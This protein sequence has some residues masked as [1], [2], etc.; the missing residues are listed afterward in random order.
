[1]RIGVG[2]GEAACSPTSQSIIADYFPAGK[3]ASAISILYLGI[4][5]GVVCSA[6]GTGYIVEHY[7]WREAFLVVGAPGLL[8]AVLVGL[9]LKEPPRGRFDPPADGSEPAP[10][11]RQVLSH[12]IHE[13]GLM[14][15]AFGIMF[16][17]MSA[18]SFGQFFHPLLVRFSGMGYAEAA[19]VFGIISVLTMGIGSPL[20]GYVTERF[21][22]RDARLICW[23]P[24]I[25]IALSVPL[26]VAGFLSGSDAAMLIMIAVG[27]ALFNMYHGPAFAAIHN[28]TPAS[29]RATA[30]SIAIFLSAFVG[31]GMGPLITGL[32]SDAFANGLYVGP[33]TYSSSCGFDALDADPRLGPACKMASGMGL[34]YALV[35]AQL[36]SAL[37][38]L[39]L[40]IAGW[41]I[42]RAASGEKVAL[43]AD[44][45]VVTSEL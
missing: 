37:G 21:A 4:P 13:P 23:L 39:C 30:T 5:L 3:R 8:L 10:T 22:K 41:Q 20:G 17:G 29:M 45:D 6:F 26:N 25:G 43:G 14:F 11:T 34:R 44:D 33:G 38:A 40:A 35:G 1:M 9:I 31:L 15:V 42:G 36:F 7:G 2:V 27:G 28:R 12:M 16:S 19:G 32:F 24:A 18:Y